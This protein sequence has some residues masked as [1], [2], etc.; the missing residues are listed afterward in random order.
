MT[1]EMEAEAVVDSE[2]VLAIVEDEAE[3]EIVVEVTA[4]AG[5][6]E[7]EVVVGVVVME[8]KGSGCQ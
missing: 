5:P 2:V 1:L 8:T 4:A 3:E 6:A 7:I